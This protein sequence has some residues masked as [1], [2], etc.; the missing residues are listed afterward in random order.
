MQRVLLLALTAASLP[1]AVIRG[2]V[3]ENQTG[4]PLARALVSLE[5]VG[6]GP[7]LSARTNSYGTFEFSPVPAGTY[8]IIASRRA[9]ASV[10]FGQKRWNSSGTPIAAA[11]GETPFITI[12][13][14]RYAVVT[15]IVLD[16]NDVGLPDHDVVVY[17]NTRPPLLLTRSRTDDRGIYR[18]SGLEP[19]KYLVRTATRPEADGGYLPTFYRDVTYLDQAT[20]VEVTLDQQLENVNIRPVPGRLFTLTGHAFAPQRSSITVTL[21]SDTGSQVAEIDSQGNFRFEPAAPGQYELV[22]QAE[23]RFQPQGR[24]INTFLYAAFYPLTLDRD[25][26]VTLSLAAYPGIQF[27]F[28]DIKGQPLDRQLPLKV[29]VR[30]KELFGPG[31]PETMRPWRSTN[32]LPGRYEVALEANQGWYA[33]HVGNALGDAISQ[34]RADGWNEVFLAPGSQD[35]IKFVVSN[36]PATLH[37][38][39]RDSGG[40]AVPDM[41]VFLEAFDLDRRRRAPELHSGRTD[42]TGQYRFTGLAPGVY[43]VLA[44]S[45]YRTAEPSIMDAP[46]AKTVRLEEGRDVLQDLE[47][48]VIR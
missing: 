18:L 29:L 15:G 35:T 4:H 40:A 22:A 19:G 14:P 44:T 6:P 42:A 45:E 21:N 16:E 17:R 12:R 37:G 47:P 30:R 27:V 34:G 5:A 39:A 25:N 24:E 38:F 31:K 28:E 3:V 2:T 48:Y 43:R 11:E 23:G 13:L 7:K 1:A 32:L 9:F 20:P 41:P 26:S 33:V 46:A 8:R 36:A 10:E